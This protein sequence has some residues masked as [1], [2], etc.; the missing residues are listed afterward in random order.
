MMRNLHHIFSFLI[1]G[2]EDKEM[3][4]DSV[5]FAVILF[6]TWTLFAVS[7]LHD[8]NKDQDD[9]DED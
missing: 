1:I 9:Y 6:I 5:T 3:W 8:A 4:K 2:K 7:Y